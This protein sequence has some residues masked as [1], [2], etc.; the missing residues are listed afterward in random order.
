MAVT[1]DQ[2]RDAIKSAYRDYTTSGVPASGPWEPVK[3]EIRAALALL[4]VAL[5][6]GGFSEPPDW[7]ADLATVVSQLENLDAAVAAAEAARAAA[8]T[9]V[10]NAG[11]AAVSDVEGARDEAVADISVATASVWDDRQN[12]LVDVSRFP[13]GAAF[14]N[15]T[16]YYQATPRPV[17]PNLM[18][19]R[20]TSSN[21]IAAPMRLFSDVAFSLWGVTNATVTDDY[22]ADGA[23]RFQTSADGYLHSGLHATLP[24]G[25]YT[26]VT[27]VK[28]NTEE[29]QAFKMGRDVGQVSKTALASDYQFQFTTV[30][31]GG[32]VL[33]FWP[34]R[35]NDLGVTPLDLL[36]KGAW[37][38]AGTVD[39]NDLD[40]DEF[41]SAGHFYPGWSGLEEDF[42]YADG[43]IDMGTT[44]T[45]GVLQLAEG[46]TP[47]AFTSSVVVRKVPGETGQRIH[48]ALSRAQDPDEF[49]HRIDWAGSP[50]PVQGANN[51]TGQAYNRLTGHVGFSQPDGL[52]EFEGRGSHLVT[53]VYSSASGGREEFWLDD[54]C[55]FQ[56]VGQAVTPINFRD[57]IVNAFSASLTGSLAY[58]DMGFWNRALT[59]A[60]I[61]QAFNAFQ[62]TGRQAGV[63]L[64]G[65][66]TGRYLFNIGCSISN[67]GSPRCWPEIASPNFDPPLFPSDLAIV[68]YRLDHWEAVVPDL[69]RFFP[70]AMNGRKFIFVMESFGYNDPITGIDPEDE[71]AVEAAALA[72]GARLRALAETI[73]AA[74]AYVLVATQIPFRVDDL[75]I[76]A[77]P[78]LNGYIRDGEGVWHDGTIDWQADP[79][80]GPDAAHDDPQWYDPVDPFH[81]PTEA[82]QEIMAAIAV[83]IINSI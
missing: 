34:I 60:E 48:V 28:S 39:P 4:V 73:R 75:S 55:L 78:Y 26:L 83:D 70:P 38:F 49:T 20:A 81:H 15:L 31:H 58:G 27:R 54:V 23:S 57:F 18:T 56:R 61:R 45:L 24:A 11:T 65:D 2:I 80:I 30:T 64:N 68:G 19:S 66:T 63:T 79:D 16:K 59:D 51:T 12:R 43:E 44:P 77:R 36:I 50:G 35:S 69:L 17:V 25:D 41:E 6:D 62:E 74:G 37:V 22:T 42:V 14:L 76:A 7:A 72:F 3:Q 21:L 10:E 9:A 32:G 52:W 71:A 8:V 67:G 40:P 13:G 46:R 47:V 29:D 53:H 1:F 82:A 33:F 5:D